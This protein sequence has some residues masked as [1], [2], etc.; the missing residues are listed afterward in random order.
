MDYTKKTRAL[1]DIESGLLILKI[2]HFIKKKMSK[3]HY[4]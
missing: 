3:N 4:F 2:K 1:Q